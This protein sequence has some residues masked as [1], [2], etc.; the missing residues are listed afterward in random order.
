MSGSECKYFMF[1]QSFRS[2]QILRS[3]Q[4]FFE[5]ISATKIKT[6][7][8]HFS[9]NVPKKKTPKD[10]SIFFFLW[11]AIKDFSLLDIFNYHLLNETSNTSQWIVIQAL[12]SRVKHT[13]WKIFLLCVIPPPP[14][15]ESSFCPKCLIFNVI[16]RTKPKNHSLPFYHHQSPIRPPMMNQWWSLLQTIWISLHPMECM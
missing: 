11:I 2:F 4:K 14:L 9:K 3:C 5:E 15:N 7:M 8:K 6:F 10:C 12:N 16:I 13:K 1:T